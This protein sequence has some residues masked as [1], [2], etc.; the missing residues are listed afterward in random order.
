VNLHQLNGSW[1][2]VVVRKQHELTISE[3]LAG[4]GYATAV[5]QRPFCSRCKEN[6]NGR[7]LFPGYL[8]LRFDVTNPWHI[9]STPGVLRIVAFGEVVPPMHDDEVRNL[10]I[11]AACNRCKSV[12]RHS[13]PGK[14]VAITNGSLTGLRGM[15][16]R[17]GSI[18][19]LVI[20]VPMFN[21]SVSVNLEDTD[22]MAM[23]T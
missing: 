10:S 8:F 20:S 23:T 9:V 16:S 1:I 14:L 17:N 4:R 12:L 2:V 15:F 5:P 21:R 22:V 3:I 7:P 19:R 18:G 11:L 6:C 13:V